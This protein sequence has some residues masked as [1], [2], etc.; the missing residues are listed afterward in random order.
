MKQS[1]LLLLLILGI[2]TFTLSS[3]SDD[4]NET[5]P[6]EVKDIT[7]IN[8]TSYSDWVYFSFE[9][10]KV[11]DVT[12]FKNDTSW[13]IAFH[14]GDVRLN[15]G[16]SGKGQGAVINTENK[17]WSK[18]TEA[19]KT[20][21]VTDKIGTITTS[22][23]GSNVTTAD[24]PFSQTLTGWMTVD[25][26]DPVGNNGPKYIINNWIYVVKTADG[27][28]VKLW[29]YDNKSEKN[30]AGYFSFKYQYNKSGTTSFE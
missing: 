6:G 29:I 21:Y 1:N 22:F 15:G 16:E 30:S 26:S 7:F 25:T 11:V 13:D 24:E 4:D 5:L 17:E 12:D 2:F 23:T 9:K 18:V 20:G 3:C 27:E 8:A 14:R 19:T 10:G 28:Y